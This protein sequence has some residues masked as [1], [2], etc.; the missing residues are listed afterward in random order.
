LS[1][2]PDQPVNPWGRQSFN[3]AGFHAAIAG[4]AGVRAVRATGAGQH[5]DLSMHEAVC[6]TVEQLFFQYWFDDVQQ[7]PKVAPRQGSLHWIGAYE[8]VPAKSGWLMIT[9]TPDVPALL[10]WMAEEGS[11]GAVELASRSL[12]EVVSDVPYL[13]KVMTA[14]AGTKDATTLFEGAQA[15]HI[16]FG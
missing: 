9:P 13:M 6:T 3:V 8:V 10:A 12:I 11:E 5:V 4:L 16:A 7:Y 1:G 15:R 14:F 2:L